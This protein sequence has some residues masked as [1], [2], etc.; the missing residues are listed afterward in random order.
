MAGGFSVWLLLALSCCVILLQ[1]AGVSRETGGHVQVGQVGIGIVVVARM[2]TTTTTTTMTFTTASSCTTP[3]TPTAGEPCREASKHLFACR[4]FVFVAAVSI[5]TPSRIT[6]ALCTSMGW[7]EQQSPAD[8]GCAA[9]VFGQ[10]R[11][12]HVAGC[13]Q[14]LRRRAAAARYTSRCVT[15]GCTRA[16]AAAIGDATFGTALQ[17]GG[18]QL[19]H[20]LFRRV[21]CPVLLQATCLARTVLL[22]T[23]GVQRWQAATRER[24]R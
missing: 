2:T 7:R 11:C 13:C 1:A 24:Q 5:P 8:A 6:T 18:E 4:R 22:R 19:L 15:R 14:P 10:L 3:C 21:A 17:T 12:G 20:Q 23:V 9:A 16:R